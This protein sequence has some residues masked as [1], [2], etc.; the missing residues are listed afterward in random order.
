M[1]VE[2]KKLDEAY[3]VIKKD[4]EEQRNKSVVIFV[5]Q[6]V[7]SLC[8]FKILTHLL[9]MDAIQ[10]Q[11]FPVSGYSDLKAAND[12]HLQ[13]NED[14]RSVVMINCG[15]TVDLQD[16]LQLNENVS[17]YVLD[18]HRPYNL[19]NVR[20][21][22]LQI[23]VLDD[24]S[25]HVDEGYP[26]DVS[27]GSED[28][29]ESEGEFK[30]QSP[31][32]RKVDRQLAISDYYRGTSYASPTSLLAYELSTLLNRDSN[33]TLWLSL[34]GLTDQ[35][36]NDRMNH[37]SYVLT[38]QE[39]HQAVLNRNEPLQDKTVDEES[40]VSLA[41]DGHIRFDEDYNLVLM[42][43][44][45]LY[46]SLRHSR[47]VATRLGIWK[48]RGMCDLER[49]LAKL[50]IPL[51][52]SKQSYQFMTSNFKKRLRDQ[53]EVHAPRFQLDN[54]TFGSFFRQYEHQRLQLSAS[55]VVY[56]ISAL[57]EN[58]QKSHDDD[59]EDDTKQMREE[60]FWEAYEALSRN[61]TEMLMKGIKI[62]IDIQQNVVER[63]CALIEKGEIQSGPFRWTKMSASPNDFYFTNQLTLSKLALFVSTALQNNKRRDKPYV[64]CAEVKSRDTFL[65]CGVYGREK[66]TNRVQKNDFGTSFS[67]AARSAKARAKH[68]GFERA[69]IEVDSD[70][71]NHFLEVLSYLH[72][73]I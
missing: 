70:N 50:G 20:E 55:D 65:V 60:N 58:P 21:T 6:E 53:I 32:R 3:A 35:Y 28:S 63:G 22:N 8:A 69:L 56:S 24:D 17:V 66:H 34:V 25:T 62:C 26:S 44:W 29:S 2:R 14:V 12:S 41:E 40:P 33:D 9:Q 37:D 73:D 48:K 27:S 7:D 38:V 57:L 39:M 51:S 52:E 18:S 30:D 54:I 1:L 15:G 61:R 23:R 47:Y 71:L 5:S 4:A 42:R 31:K 13:G 11:A 10:W 72:L 64:I 68:D 67:E 45:T 46:D 16:F 49:F 36:I 19:N 43:H 59:K